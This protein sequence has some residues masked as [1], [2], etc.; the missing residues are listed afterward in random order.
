MTSDSDLDYNP[1]PRFSPN[2]IFS[3]TQRYPMWIKRN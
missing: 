2:P 3:P 1:H